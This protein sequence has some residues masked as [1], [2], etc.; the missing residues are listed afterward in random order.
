[1]YTASLF[2]CSMGA[3]CPLP[4]LCWD[5]C[6]GSTECT[7]IPLWIQAWAVCQVCSSNVKTH[8]PYFWMLL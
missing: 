1:M 4:G 2:P 7:E 8:G 5:L 6:Q 3:C